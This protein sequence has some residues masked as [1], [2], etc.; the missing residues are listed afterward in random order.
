M[1]SVSAFLNVYGTKR[2]AGFSGQA[3]SCMMWSLTTDNQ[4]L[5]WSM[6]MTLFWEARFSDGES[7]GAWNS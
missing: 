6:A 4:R 3:F 1:V 5:R 7:H 2:F